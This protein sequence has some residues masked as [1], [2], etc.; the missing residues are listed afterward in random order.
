MGKLRHIDTRSLWI[1]QALRSGKLELRKVR[2][3]VNPADLFTKHLSSEERIT[4]LLALL[5]CR[6]RS[7][8]SEEAPQMRREAGAKEELLAC[9]M[10]RQ[11]EDGGFE[12]DGYLYPTVEWEGERLPEAFPHDPRVLPHQVKGGLERLFPRVVACK[13]LQEI[14]QSEDWLE[15]RGLKGLAVAGVPA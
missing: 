13:E 15:I 7:G 12:R 5:G 9:D 3:D 4:N 10:V 1:Q 14:G 11:I 6:F 8:R 2:G